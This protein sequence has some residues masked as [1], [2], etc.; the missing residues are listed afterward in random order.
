MD[1]VIHRGVWQKK[2]RVSLGGSL[3]ALKVGSYSSLLSF[4]YLLYLEMINDIRL[5]KVSLKLDH[6]LEHCVQ[7]QGG[8]KYVA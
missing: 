6:R 8:Y 7:A 5:L 2:Q 1:D 3:G 4:Y